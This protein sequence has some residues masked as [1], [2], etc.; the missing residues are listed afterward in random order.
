MVVAT[1][2]NAQGTLGDVNIPAKTGDVL[3]WLRKK[4]KQPSLQ[5]QGKV[6]HE[7]HAFAIFASPCEEDE[8][9]NTHVLPPPFHDD[10]FQ[11]TLVIL[12]TTNL[13]GDEY[14]KPASCYTDLTPSEYDEFY[15]TCNF[16][17]EDEEEEAEIDEEE[18]EPKL[19]D[20]LE[21]PEEEKEARPAITVHTIHA[22]N[23]FVEHPLRTLVEE[24]FGSPEIEEAILNRCISEAQ[25]W[26]I[27]IDWENPV[28]KEMYRCRAI[29]L[30][31]YKD[32]ATTMTP[33]EFVETNAVDQNPRRWREIM[34]Q[35]IEKEKA[36]YN[37]EKTASIYLHCSS[38][39]R[40]TKCDYYQLQT[41]S[42]DEPMTT[43]V[44]CLECHK[45][46][47]F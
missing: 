3:E 8:E 42:A 4:L 16:E 18:E 29:Q 31:R 24:R 6:P 45:K 46:W 19:E 22:A 13:N 38:C 36:M 43:F 15:A 9:E 34:E 30:Y 23:V 7:Q 21:E 33:Q 14:E 17:Q 10:S 27:D 2:I 11:G 25:K 35:T 1:T 44:T 32:L 41:R 26:F 20:E 12:K 5:Y 40:K 28:F 37:R 47:K 39:K